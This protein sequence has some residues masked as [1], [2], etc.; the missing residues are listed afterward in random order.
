MPQL[1]RV[2]TSPRKLEY[3]LGVAEKLLAI[4]CVLE[5]RR[6]EVAFLQ[7][8]FTLEG[9]TCVV[10]AVELVRVWVRVVSPHAAS[11][12]PGTNGAATINTRPHSAC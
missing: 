9:A 3:V 5:L 8:T 1:G 7:G 4:G 11:G 10:N 2:C 12:P 6:T